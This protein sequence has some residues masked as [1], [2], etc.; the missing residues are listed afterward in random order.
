MQEIATCLG[1]A[2]LPTGFHEAAGEIYERLS[3][4]K[5]ATVPPSVE[6]AATRLLRRR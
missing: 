1:E 4:Y 2:G 5:D 6:E 3:G